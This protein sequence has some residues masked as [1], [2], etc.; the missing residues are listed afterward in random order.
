MQN[1]KNTFFLRTTPVAASG[2][3]HCEVFLKRFPWFC[4]FSDKLVFQKGTSIENGSWI[5]DLGSWMVICLYR[6]WITLM[7]R[8]KPFIKKIQVKWQ[9]TFFSLNFSD[10]LRSNGWR[11]DNGQF[12]EFLKIFIVWKWRFG[13]CLS[14]LLQES[15]YIHTIKDTSLLLFFWNIILEVVKNSNKNPGRLSNF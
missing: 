6:S 15:I 13:V 5:L 8:C 1:F 7:Q 14:L 2:N 12:L 10:T 11:Q 9:L 3:C 4:T